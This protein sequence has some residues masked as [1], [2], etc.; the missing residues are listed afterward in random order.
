MEENKRMQKARVA[1]AK[2]EGQV[3]RRNISEAE[4]MRKKASEAENEKTGEQ[5]MVNTLRSGLTSQEDFVVHALL[6]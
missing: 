5:F 1:T 6:L 3:R 4:E 2:N